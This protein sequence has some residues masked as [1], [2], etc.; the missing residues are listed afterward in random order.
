V[1]D[2]TT[3]QFF[4]GTKMK[5]AAIIVLVLSILFMNVWNEHNWHVLVLVFMGYAAGVLMEKGIQKG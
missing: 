5:I 2:L 4:E 1:E 3:T